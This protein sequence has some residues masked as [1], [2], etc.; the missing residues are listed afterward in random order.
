MLTK[1][2]YLSGRQ[3]IKRLWIEEQAR[4]LLGPASPTMAHLRR[5]GSEVGRLARAH[6]PQGQ[7]I[8]GVGQGAVA[9]TVAALHKGATCLFEARVCA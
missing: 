7:V 9:A 5:Q 1:S 2:K 8:G 3:C 4:E 6:F